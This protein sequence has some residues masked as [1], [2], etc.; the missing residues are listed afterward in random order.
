M[1][2]KPFYGITHRQNSNSEV[3]ENVDD[4]RALIRE[5]V[6]SAFQLSGLNGKSPF[7]QFIPEGARVLLKPNWVLHTNQSGDTMKCMITSPAFVEAVIAEVR[8]CNASEIWIGDAP[9]Q[10]CDWQQIV[11]PEIYEALK[12]AAGPVKLKI[13]DFRRTIIRD[14]MLDHQVATDVRP[15]SE[16]ILFNLGQRSML[17][18]I[19]KPEGRFRV[20]M[21]DPRELQKNHS[22]GNHQ[23][24]LSRE[25]FE[26]DVIINLPKL[27]THR[28]AGM[29]GALKNLVGIN[30]N[31]DYLPHHRIGGTL[32]E[33]D[34]Y[35]GFS[36]VKRMVELLLDLANQNIGKPPSRTYRKM[37]Y[38]LLD[39]HHKLTGDREIEGAWYGNDTV[40]RMVHDINRLLLYG[41]KD[42]TVSN[43]R[44]R[45][46]WSLTDALVVGER[47][48]PLAPHARWLGVVTFGNNSLWLDRIHSYLM[49]LDPDRIS[50]LVPTAADDYPIISQEEMV[51]LIWLKGK[52]YNIRELARQIGIKAQPPKGWL[53][54]CEWEK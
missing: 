50:M 39:A 12:K 40:W 27:K 8:E 26:A 3:Y 16:Y 35:R 22:P 4:L 42:G 7:N 34:C 49:G 15:S 54:H 37:A 18:P 1:I 38:K 24:L 9:I 33:G 10:G 28:K 32:Q 5:A 44:Q 25:A 31:K 21:Y 11:T 41:N 13:I 29:T 2:Y 47:E 14:Q 6:S 17:E 46:I 30:G 20:T 36:P 43:K 45:T 48:G 23:Y 53:N 51:D 52:S 19:S